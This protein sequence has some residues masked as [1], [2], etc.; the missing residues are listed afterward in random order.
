MGDG[1]C[2]E[3]WNKKVNECGSKL[4]RWSQSKFKLRGRQ[5]EEMM[6]HLGESQKNWGGNI[7]KIDALS[8][9][10]NKL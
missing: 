9:K 5:I 6:H 7:A 2:M 1:D 8:R 10:V 4:S 3:M